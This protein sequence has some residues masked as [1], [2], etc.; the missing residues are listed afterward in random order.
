MPPIVD[1]AEGFLRQLAGELTRPRENECL[2]CYVA[3][4]LDEFPCDGSHRHA[5][6]YRDTMAPRATALAARLRQ[7]GAC[8]CDCELF[9]NGY[10]LRSSSPDYADN[11]LVDDDDA[12]CGV[13]ALPRCEGVRRGS[14]QPCRNWVRIRRR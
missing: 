5:F 4:L 12:A 10:E 7:L 13:D 1:E 11:E 9:L 3:R 6:R 14:V 8:C 2:C